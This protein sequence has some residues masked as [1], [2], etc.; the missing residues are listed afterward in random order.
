VPRAQL[1]EALRQQV[2][3]SHLPCFDD[4]CSIEIGKE[5]AAQKTLLTEIVR[6]GSSCAVTCTLVDLRTGVSERGATRK[7][8][9]DP[10]NLVNSLEIAVLQI[11]TPRPPPASEHAAG[12]VPPPST[13]SGSPAITPLLELREMERTRPNV[14]GVRATVRYDGGLGWR[15]SGGGEAYYERSLGDYVSLGLWF[16]AIPERMH[17]HFELTTEVRVYPIEGGSQRFLSWAFGGRRIRRFRY[18]LLRFRRV[19]SVHWSGVLRDFGVGNQF[20]G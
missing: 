8:G 15:W 16:Y 11:R 7:G 14:L 2:A 13:P 3:D 5:V 18:R 19:A 6:V 17:H 20:L 9:C 12:D 1:K 4:A 10:D